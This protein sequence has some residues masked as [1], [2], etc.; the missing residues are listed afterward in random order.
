[1]NVRAAIA[2]CL[3]LSS[4]VA[5]SSA[6]QQT[7]QRRQRVAL[8]FDDLPD[9]GPLPPGLTRVDVATSIIEALKSHHA[10][11]VYGFI[12]AKQLE[13]H[14]ADIEVLRVWRAAGFPLGN[15]TF[16]HMDLDA[17][18]VDDFERDVA[19][20]EPTLRSLMSDRDWHWF[21]YPYLREGNTSDKY[22]GVKAM[23]ARRG[24]RVAEVTLSFDDYA[25]NDPYAR[26][27]TRND[28]EGIAWLEKSY[29][30]RAAE[31]LVRGPEAARTL[32]GHDIG[33][34]MLLHI[35]AFETVMLPRLLE[36]LEQHGFELSTLED[37][38]K[39]AVYGTLPDTG[40]NWSGTLLDQMAA[41]RRLPPAP[42]TDAFTR[43]AALCR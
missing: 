40:G 21:R 8:T 10:P 26:C 39:D 22:R 29:E 23:L 36:I 1:M 12:N 27:L 35:G 20:N 3:C 4:L 9:H 14:P 38:Q 41:A 43:L 17:N 24:Y 37:A 15:H 19:A 28:R 31:S 42:A 33:H 32:A 7:D 34:V 16:S 18:S 2:G 30:T 13:A 25:Y 6:Q 5:L 11:P